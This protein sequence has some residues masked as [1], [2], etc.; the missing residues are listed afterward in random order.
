MEEKKYPPPILV[1]ES[2]GMIHVV[3]DQVSVDIPQNGPVPEG[4]PAMALRIF[5]GF[6]RDLLPNPDAE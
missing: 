3:Y 5:E 1:T 2:D 4:V 6:R